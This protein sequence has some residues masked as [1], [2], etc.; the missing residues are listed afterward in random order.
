MAVMSDMTYARSTTG[1]KALISEL[2]ADID[3][4]VKALTGSEYDA[5]LKVVKTYWVGV[6]ETKFETVIKQSVADLGTKFK[7]YK[8]QISTA[9]TADAQQFSTMQKSNADSISKLKI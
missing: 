9:L 7:S 6:D 4:A 3:R 2:N 8:T 5:L 1:Q